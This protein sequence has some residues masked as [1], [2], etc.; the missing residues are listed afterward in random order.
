MPCYYAG[1]GRYADAEGQPFSPDTNEGTPP[2]LISHQ[3]RTIVRTSLVPA[4]HHLPESTE[5][6]IGL[7][8]WQHSRETEGATGVVRDCRLYQMWFA[9]ISAKYFGMTS[10]ASQFWNFW[11]SFFRDFRISL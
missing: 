2:R 7:T 9:E 6:S 8:F 4:S 11:A 1:L 3:L 5:C 10:R